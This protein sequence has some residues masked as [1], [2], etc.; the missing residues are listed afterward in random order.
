MRGV[1][2]C[3]PGARVRAS[4]RDHEARAPLAA[5][6]IVVGFDGMESVAQFGAE[7][8]VVRT[9]EYGRPD[10]ARLA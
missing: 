3:W 7:L 10:P 6:E 4:L 5:E 9:D 2:Q 1:G 8:P